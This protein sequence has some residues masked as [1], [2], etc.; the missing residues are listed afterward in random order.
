LSLQF[1]I[2]RRLMLKLH[3]SLEVFLL[4]VFAHDD[5][6]CGGNALIISPMQAIRSRSEST[7]MPPYLP[8]ASWLC[9]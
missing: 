3:L 4:N 8:S 6:A 9:F 7:Y 5:I 2:Q 1:D